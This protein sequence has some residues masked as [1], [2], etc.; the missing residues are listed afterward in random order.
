MG[1]Y[2]ACKEIT[3]GTPIYSL[4]IIISNLFGDEEKRAYSYMLLQPLHGASSSNSHR[5]E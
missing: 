2:R 5:P 3:E 4:L 1:R